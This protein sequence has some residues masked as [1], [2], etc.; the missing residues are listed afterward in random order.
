MRIDEISLGQIGAGIKGAVAGA[1]QSAQARKVTQNTQALAQTALTQWGKK[2]IA[3]TNAAGG[4]PVDPTDYTNHLTDF[5]QKVML[6]GTRVQDLDPSSQ[7]KVAA[8]IKGVVDTRGD[9]T[10]LPQAFNALV[11]QASVA[12]PDPAKVRGGGG[13]TAG[14]F[15]TTPVQNLQI[16]PATQT[17]P[18]MVKYKNDIYRLTD[19]TKMIWMDKNDRQASETVSALLS[20]AAQS[21]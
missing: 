10:K 18:T 8:A 21:I 12:R 2:V 7:P 16:A 5:V 17:T 3:L 1:Q 6:G 14:G 11:T 13:A 4:Q 9:R 20:M 15:V 19:A